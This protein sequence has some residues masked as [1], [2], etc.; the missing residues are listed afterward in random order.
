MFGGNAAAD[1]IPGR[2]E[3]NH[4]S[5]GAVRSTMA[6]KEIM[7]ENLQQ[8][9]T[10]SCNGG[11]LGD[12]FTSENLQPSKRRHLIANLRDQKLKK[13]ITNDQQMINIAQ[14]E[15]VLQEQMIKKIRE[16]DNQ[17]AN[18]IKTLSESNT[19]IGQSLSE[20]FK[21]IAT[22][23]A[24]QNQVAQQHPD[25][26]S[27]FHVPPYQRNHTSYASAEFGLNNINEDPLSG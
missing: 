14:K 17:Q 27:R 13:K 21:S 7:V 15:L 8:T 23:I 25:I 18:A 6:E 19:S 3:T 24:S 4:G 10:T 12:E 2:I 11:S 16:S 20:G 9:A 26:S 22:V 1:E 5:F